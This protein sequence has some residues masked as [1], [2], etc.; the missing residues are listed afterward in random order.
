MTTQA[1]VAAHLRA[2]LDMHEQLLTQAVHHA[3]DPAMPGGEAMAALGHVANHEAWENLNDATERYGRAYTSVADEDPDEAWSPY[4]TLAF[5][6]EAWRIERDADYDSR[7]TLATEANFLRWSLD[8]AWDNEPGWDDF[9]ADVKAAKD[10]LEAILYEGERSTF[11]GVPCLADECRGTR[12]VRKTE[13]TKDRHGNKVWRLSDWH[14]PRCK[15]KWDEDA[16]ARMV[17]VAQRYAEVEHIDGETWCSPDRAAREVGCKPGT[18]RTWM[19]R[20]QVARICVRV[21]R[22]MFVRLADVEQRH[23]EDLERKRAKRM[24]TV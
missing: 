19:H 9:A 1:T 22:R 2:I 13:P 8:W 3:G 12:L 16:Y 18:L 4:Q 24:T 11:R 14:C 17:V 21:G 23:A 10:K 15:R 6:A 20:G 5:W 7:R